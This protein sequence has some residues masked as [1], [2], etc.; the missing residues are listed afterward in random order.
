MG[1]YD[2]FLED[3]KANHTNPINQATHLVGIPLIICSIPLFFFHTKIALMMF[4]LGWVLQIIGHI[5]EGKPPS[6]L[7]NP[8]FLVIGPL[9]LL[10]KIIG[11][12]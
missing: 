10:R 5:F 1:I 6:F 3:Y 7:K 2:N 12:K 11:R 9:W 4:V 8:T